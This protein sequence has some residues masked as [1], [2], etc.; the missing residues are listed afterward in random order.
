MA[1]VPASPCGDVAMDSGRKAGGHRAWFL[2]TRFFRGC[3]CLAADWP[4][5]WS[6]V[7]VVRLPCDGSLAR[8]GLRR[9]QTAANRPRAVRSLKIPVT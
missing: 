5:V 1:R 7:R 6:V 8:D 2:H 4:R 9:V 3:F